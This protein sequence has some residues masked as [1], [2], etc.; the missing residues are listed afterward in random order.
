MAAVIECA[1]LT[2]ASFNEVSK[3]LISEYWVVVVAV[4][5]WRDAP[6]LVAAEE[7]LSRCPLNCAII[8]LEERG[9]ASRRSV[10][11]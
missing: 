1:P 3:A 11:G 6:L 4:R 8:S 10:G 9:M 7:R 2:A 5:W